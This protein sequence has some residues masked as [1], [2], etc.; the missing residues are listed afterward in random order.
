MLKAQQ[1][2]GVP[3]SSLPVPGQINQFNLGSGSANVYFG[4]SASRRCRNAL[5]R[6]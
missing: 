3:S 5:G 1:G 2:R 4:I 6:R